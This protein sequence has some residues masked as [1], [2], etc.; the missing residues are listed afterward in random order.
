MSKIIILTAPSGSS[1]TTIANHLLQNFDNLKFSV[2]ATTRE[3]RDYEINGVHYH[4]MNIKQFKDNIEAGNFLEYQEVY[5]NQ[6]YGT[7]L[8]EVKA[9]WDDH[10]VILFDI[11][12]KGS[13]NIERDMYDVL[14]IYIKAPSIEVLRQRLLDRGTETNES[15]EKRIQKATEELEYSKY[16]DYVITNDQ[17]E[18]ACRIIKFI[19]QDFMK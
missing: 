1:K 11:D 18:R 4:F 14:S 9:A 13:L 10:K 7:L 17:L 2:S 19:V 8:S 5:P 16:F 15:L 6:F 3:K 12:V